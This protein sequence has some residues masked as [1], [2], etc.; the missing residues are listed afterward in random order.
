MAM[1][2]DNDKSQTLLLQ[3]FKGQANR[4]PLWFMRQAGRSLPDYRALKERHSFWEMVLDP[5]LCCEVTVMPVEQLG[6]DAAIFFSD[7]LT[8]PYNMGFQIDFE[9][10]VGPQIANPLTALADL[11]KL[12]PLAD[13]SFTAR[14]IE[15]INATLPAEI[16][17]IGF[18]GSPFTVLTYLIE[19]GSSKSFSKVMGMMYAR[20]EEFHAIMQRM[21]DATIDYL[22]MK[23]EAGVAAFQLFDT[24]GGILR[25]KDFR[26]FVLPYVQQ[27]FDAVELPSIYYLKNCAHLIDEMVAAGSDMLSLGETVDIATNQTLIKSGKGVQG[28]LYSGLLYAD[29]KTVAREVNQLLSAAKEH[30]PSY[31]FNLSHGINP[32][33]NPDM[34]RFIVDEVK[35]FE[36]R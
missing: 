7:I 22:N 17:L 25:P 26:A 36:W 33:V 15:K 14:A 29:K 6:V 5:E 23:K 34:V 27:I 13:T 21:T 12:T 32:D 9:K 18:A 35:A 2:I 31:I 1:T 30:Y 3:A 16:P 19:G 11:D 20:P 24:W 28:N 4:V 10:G 8:L